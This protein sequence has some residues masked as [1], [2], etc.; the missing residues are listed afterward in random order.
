MSD[1]WVKEQS[2]VELA[3]S[4][5][6]VRV[7]IWLTEV[8][9]VDKRPSKFFNWGAIILSNMTMHTETVNIPNILRVP[10][11]LYSQSALW[12]VE[13]TYAVP[14]RRKDAGLAGTYS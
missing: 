6:N 1:A 4:N 12:A 14:L 13:T 11:L 8:T 9:S 3:C 7:D 10:V 2:K 5:I